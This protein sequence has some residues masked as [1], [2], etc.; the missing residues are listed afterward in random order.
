MLS[1]RPAL[2][3]DE[4][5][6]IHEHSLDLLENLGI[7]YKTPKA[8]EILEEKGCPVDYDRNWASFP[9]DLVEWTIFQAPRVVR[10]G[11]GG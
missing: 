4:V 2:K 1:L 6:R 11:I 5:E 10:V 3:R 9:P 8:M 7:E